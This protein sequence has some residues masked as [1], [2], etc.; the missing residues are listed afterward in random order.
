M[1][2]EFNPEDIYR[3]ANHINAQTKKIGDEVFFRTCPYCK[4]K[5]TRD[6]LRTFSIN[7]RNGVFKCFR[8]SCGVTGNMVTL[9][10]DFDFSLGKEIDE[11][12]RPK[13]QYKKLK[14]PE[15]PIQPKPKAIEYLLSR[16]IS[17]EI[18]KKYEITVQNNN[19]HVLV[20]PFFDDTGEMCF[21]KYRDT[22]FKKDSGGNKEWCEKGCK[23]ILFGM[24]QCNCQNKRLIVNEGQI[25]SLSVATAFKGQI[26]VVSVPTGAMGFTWVPYCW[27]WVNSFDEIIVFGD[28]EKGKITLLE[29]FSKRFQGKVKHVRKTDYKDCKDANEILLKY[30]P[31]YLRSCVENSVFEPVKRVIPIAEVKHQEVERFKTGFKELDDLLLGG[32]PFGYLTILTGVRGEGKSTAA[33][34]IVAYALEE[35]YNSFIYSGE[36]TN[37]NAKNWLDRQVAGRAV[38]EETTPTGYLRYYIRNSTMEKLNSWYGDRCYIYDNSMV[39]DEDEDLIKT[40]EEV[41]NKYSVRVILID[42]LMT[43][44]DSFDSREDKYEKQSRLCKRLARIAQRYCVSIILVA[45]KRKRGIN[46]ADGASENDEVNGSSDI[47]NLAGVV[48][49]YGMNNDDATKSDYPRKLKCI[50]ERINGRVNYEGIPM[51]YD[52]RSKRIYGD[53][54]DV[55]YMFSWSKDGF[56]DSY[57][58]SPFTID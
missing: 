34:Q 23:P 27:D 12:Y 54:D 42:N 44:L 39:D 1:K 26:N 52:E 18:A 22:Q 9:S 56:Y 48:L 25:D 50:K 32:L 37:S 36:L 30:G 7:Y 43:A 21:V 35:N 57:E 17:D 31:E 49:S 4:P 19:E 45:H 13:R 53:K 28:F 58:D 6:N 8:S 51:K 40:I 3:F 47:T 55:N 5:E 11:Y 29:E 16:G 24:K 15:K 33:E 14:T 46:I 20:F 41:I 2:Y 38:C 10:K